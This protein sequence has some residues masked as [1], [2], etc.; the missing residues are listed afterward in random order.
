VRGRPRTPAADSG[1]AVTGGFGS[2]GLPAALAALAL[3]GF[4]LHRRNRGKHRSHRKIP[5]V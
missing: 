4:G 2:G 3:A 1:C 5:R